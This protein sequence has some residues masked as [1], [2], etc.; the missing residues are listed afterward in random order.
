MDQI[1]QSTGWQTANFDEFEKNIDDSCHYNSRVYHIRK[2]GELRLAP[3]ETI[4]TSLIFF[5]LLFKPNFHVFSLDG[6]QNIVSMHALVGVMSNLIGLILTVFFQIT[7]LIY[8][9]KDT[10]S[11]LNCTSV[12]CTPVDCTSGDLILRIICLGT[13]VVNIG[14]EILQSF[15]LRRYIQQIPIWKDDDM[16]ICTQLETCL[17]AQNVKVPTHH[18]VQYTVTRISKGGITCKYRVFM[19]F[20]FVIKCTIEIALLIIGSS[21]VVYSTSNA[22]LILNTLSVIFIINIDNFMY[23]FFVSSSYKNILKGGVPE[24]GLVSGS[25]HKEFSIAD[26]K[27][28]KYWQSYASFYIILYISILVPSLYKY[29]C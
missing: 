10:L 22:N 9:H 18:G 26:N 6:L 3:P 21:Y 1:N 14:S 16:E 12:D 8:L 29:W 24:L 17:V 4:F 23:G 7:C 5:P 28:D 2:G 11:S 13:F 25:P 27:M 15:G 20:I 19:Y